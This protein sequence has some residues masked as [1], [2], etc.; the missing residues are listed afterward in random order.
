MIITSVVNCI[1]FESRKVISLIVLFALLLV[2]STPLLVFLL[3][4][5][6]ICF[7]KYC[8][9]FIG[10]VMGRCNQPEAG[11][12]HP[13]ISQVSASDTHQETL[14][15]CNPSNNIGP[16]H[17]YNSQPAKTVNILVHQKMGNMQNSYI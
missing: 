16:V 11:D 17:L 10:Q 5:F 9:K 7:Q 14:E 8:K 12:K 13:I 6:F 1:G 2:K 3:H 4:I 15:L